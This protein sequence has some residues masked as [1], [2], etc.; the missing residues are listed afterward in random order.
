M[1]DQ[2]PE[3]GQTTPE[4]NSTGL[5]PDQELELLRQK[6]D[7]LGINY[8]PRI[9]IDTLRQRINEKLEGKE[10]AVPTAEDPEEP[11]QLTQAQM[12]Q[13]IREDQYRD[14]MALLRCR[15]YNLNPKKNDLQGEIIT[16]GNRFVGTVRKFI[17]FGEAT[18]NGY[19][20]PRIIYNELKSR[21]FQQIG[22]KTVKGQIEVKT[23]LVPEYN[24]EVL[25][26]LT[27]EEL[28][29]LALSQAAAERVGER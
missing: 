12:E 21:K 27:K 7:N 24:I 1:T 18:D 5:T 3:Q 20:I 8:G 11:V 19:H 9:G 23:R 15:I 25:P 4:E 10:P 2:T 16:V 28:E 29:E 17:P 14:E 26:P 22:T 13:K 6:A